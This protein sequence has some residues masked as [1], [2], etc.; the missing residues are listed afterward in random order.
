MANRQARAAIPPVGRR[1]PAHGLHANHALYQ[2]HHSDAY[3]TGEHGPPLAYPSTDY[4][5]VQGPPL[6]SSALTGGFQRGRAWAVREQ[7]RVPK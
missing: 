6:H 3:E 1:G 4:Q 5:V 7:C 2:T